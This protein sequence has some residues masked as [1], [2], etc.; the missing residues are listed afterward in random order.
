MLNTNFVVLKSCFKDQMQLQVPPLKST[1]KIIDKPK[2]LNF[3]RSKKIVH[4]MRSLINEVGHSGIGNEDC[5]SHSRLT[6]DKAT[7]CTK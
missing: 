4:S 1:F 2:P 3:Q 7:P 6:S 5:N